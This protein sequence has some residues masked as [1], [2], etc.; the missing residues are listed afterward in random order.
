MPE[1]VGAP[2]GATIPKRSLGSWRADRRLH[3]KG[4]CDARKA[5]A[6]LALRKRS[7]MRPRVFVPLLPKQ[8]C[9]PDH[10]CLR[11][12][13]TPSSR[14]LKNR[15]A[16]ERRARRRDVDNEVAVPA[17]GAL[18][19]RRRRKGKKKVGKLFISPAFA[20]YSSTPCRRR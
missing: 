16:A 19:S 11:A 10:V 14:P 4:G 9:G 18:L 7:K 17:A 3:R 13:D 12:P 2:K 1:E 5:F 6:R 20:C 8:P 15:L